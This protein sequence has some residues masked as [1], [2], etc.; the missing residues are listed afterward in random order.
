[1]ASP[2]ASATTSHPTS[3]TTSHTTSAV[4]NRSISDL[5]KDVTQTIKKRK[6]LWDMSIFTEEGLQSKG[7]SVHGNPM[8]YYTCGDKNSKNV[9]LILSAVHGDEVV[10]V[11]FGFRLVEWLKAHSHLCE[12]AF[13]VVAPLVN[14]DGFLRYSRG[15]RTNYNKVDLNRNFDTPEWNS[16]ALKLWRT[17]FKQRRYYPGDHAASEPEVAFQKWLLEEFDPSKILTIHAPLN[18]LDY[19]GPHVEVMSAFTK[20]YVDSCEEFKAQEKKAAKT[21]DFYAY[22]V[23]PGSLGNYAGKLRGIPTFTVELP[24]IKWEMAP[25][26]FGDFESALEVFLKYELKET[27]SRRMTKKD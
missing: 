6:Y 17:K 12:G 11:Y 15:T 21:L 13:V 25:K 26:Y 9:S 2:A 20:A 4:E 7:F 8:L 3:R 16:T 10:P 14:P 19:D 18:F 23:F 5:L 22:G 24:T 27:P 1:M